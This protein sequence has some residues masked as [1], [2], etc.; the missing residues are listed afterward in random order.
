MS[1]S[2]M[3]TGL[4]QMVIFI[5]LLL[6]IVGGSWGLFKLFRYMKLKKKV[7]ELQYQELKKK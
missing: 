5:T 7:L 1:F 2:G 6:I 3:G 4:V